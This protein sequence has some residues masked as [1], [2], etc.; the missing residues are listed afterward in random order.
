[1]NDEPCLCTTHPG[2]HRKRRKGKRLCSW[3][4]DV[5]HD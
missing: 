1:M 4:A 5:C 2:C 3:C